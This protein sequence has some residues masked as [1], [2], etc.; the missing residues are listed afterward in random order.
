MKK[1]KMTQTVK[2]SP[3]GIK[4]ITYE[5]GKEFEVPDE[6]FRIFVKEGWATAKKE[7]KPVEKEAVTTKE[8]K[9]TKPRAQGK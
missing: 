6:L 3:D 1:V 9:K 5:K 2:A 8:E 4:I 7:R